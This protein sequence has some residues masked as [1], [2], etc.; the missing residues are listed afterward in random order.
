MIA[1]ESVLLCCMNM[2]DI[3]G[4]EFVHHQTQMQMILRNNNKEINQQTAPD[5]SW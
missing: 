4:H 2:Q 1:S 3:K 5:Y